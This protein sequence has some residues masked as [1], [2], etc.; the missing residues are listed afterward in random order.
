MNLSFHKQGRE[1][2]FISKEISIGSVGLLIR[3]NLIYSEMSVR[4]KDTKKSD[5]LHI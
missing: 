2:T 5:F 1:N 4:R 3:V